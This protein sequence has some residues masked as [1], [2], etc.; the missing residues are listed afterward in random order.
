MIEKTMNV[1]LN[2]LNIFSTNSL[3]LLILVILDLFSF[4]N[5]FFSS[6]DFFGTAVFFSSLVR[7]WFINVR[8]AGSYWLLLA[9]SDG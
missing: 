2:K 6:L 5:I 4:Q 8:M 9:L 1:L 7:L 3:T